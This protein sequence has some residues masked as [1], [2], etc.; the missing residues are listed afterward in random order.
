MTAVVSQSD[1]YLTSEQALSLFDCGLPIIGMD[2]ETDANDIRDGRG[3]TQG[4]S[5]SGR[6]PGL[7][8]RSCYLPFRHKNTGPGFGENLDKLF[9]SKLKEKIE[10]YEGHITFHNAKFD[11]IALKSL[12]I[13]YT[14]N[15]YCTLLIAHLL[16]ENKPYNKSLDACTEFYLKKPGKRE[17]EA[18]LALRKAFGWAGI[19]PNFMYEYAAHDARAHLELLEHLL[20]MMGED[21]VQY[22]H[23]QKMPF[24]RVMNQMESRGVRI[25]T[26][27]CKRMTVLGESAMQDVIDILGLNPGSPKDLKTLLIDELGLP[28]VKQS[29]K[30]GAPSFDKGAMEIYEEMLEL[31]DDPTAVHILEYRGWQKSVS[32]NYKPY[33]ELLSPDGR[34]RPN[35]KLHGTKTGRMS[36]EKPNLQQIPRSSGKAWNGVMK[37]AFIPEDDFKL[38]EADYSQLE[39]RL[40]TA[41]AEQTTDES[42]GLKRVFAEGRDIF[43]EMAASLRMHRPEAKTLTYTIQYGGGVTRVSS[44]FGVTS[45]RAKSII[46]NYYYTY[47]GFRAVSDRA[48]RKASI[49]GRVQLWSKRYR[50]FLYPQDEARKAFNSIIQGGAA[51]IVERTMIRLFNEIDSDDCRMLLQVHDSVVFE[52]REGMESIYGPKIQA[53]MEDVQPDF[54]VKFAVDFHEWGK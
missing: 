2:T 42:T 13:N 3:Y 31:R 16:N 38:W 50:H 40:A 45:E 54:G 18:F 9:L 11:L 35:Y 25:D 46:E 36:C 5:I 43:A 23:E 26:E 51:D 49:N 7:G 37:Q 48:K 12:G 53:I 39:L 52:I 34:L 27:L 10:G 19:P 32:S 8:I 1:Q 24:V 14:G 20:P 6:I 44:V 17:S 29:K 30:T 41:Y 28:V 21:L 4:I 33:V 22:W 47:P 15:F